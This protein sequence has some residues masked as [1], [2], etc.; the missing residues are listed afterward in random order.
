[1][2]S[3]IASIAMFEGA[4]CSCNSA[5]NCDRSSFLWAV[6]R[7]IRA[8]TRTPRSVDPSH[9]LQSIPFAFHDAGWGSGLSSSFGC[10]K[11]NIP[12]RGF[13][14]MKKLILFLLSAGLAWAQGPSCQFKG[15]F[16]SATTGTPYTNN[17]GNPNCN[18]FALTWNST[19]FTGL[20]IQL[21]GSD[22]N[23]TYTAFSGSS[24]V[25]VGSNPASTLSG[26][27]VVQASSSLA[28]IRV[29][30]PSVTGSGGINYQVYGYNG[31]TPAAR[32][33]GG[34]GGGGT[35]TQTWIAGTGGVTA[36]AVVCVSRGTSNPATA[37]ICPTAVVGSAE[38]NA[39]VLGIAQ[40]SAS[41]GASFQVIVQGPATCNFDSVNAPTAGDLAVYSFGNSPTGGLCQDSGNFTATFGVPIVGVVLTSGSVSTAQSVWVFGPGQYGS[42]TSVAS[43][44]TINNVAGS[45]N[46][47]L[48]LPVT[49]TDS[50]TKVVSF[51]S[52]S[53]PIDGNCANWLNGDLQDSGG[54]CGVT[55]QLWTAGAGGVTANTLVCVS[56]DST[57]T[58]IECPILTGASAPT[59]LGLA[60]SS[61]SVGVQ[62]T[63]NTVPGSVQNCVFDNTALIGDL[64]S[65]STST[66]GDCTD[67]GFTLL[68]ELSTFLPYVGIVQSSGTGAQSIMFVSPG[69]NGTLASV[70]GTLTYYFQ[71]TAA[72]VA[73][74]LYQQTTPYSPK[75]TLPYVSGTTV[76]TL[77]LQNWITPAGQP[78]VSFFPAGS[79]LFHIHASR[80][81]AFTG[82][83]T[84]QCQF[85]ETNSSGVDIAVIGTSGVT[86][87]LTLSEVEYIVQ[88]NNPNTYVLSSTASRIVARVQAN[89]NVTVSGNIDL[90]VGGEADSHITLPIN[91]VGILS[92]FGNSGP[93]VSSLTVPTGG[94]ISFSG[95]GTVNANQVNGTAVTGTSGNC[96]KFGAGN[97]LADNGSACGG[98]GGAVS[99]V[100]G[101]T[102]AVP[103]GL[104]LQEQHTASSSASLSFTSCISSTYDEY[105]FEILNLIPATNAVTG[106]L[107]MNSDSSSL[108]AWADWFVGTALNSDGQQFSNSDTSISLFV[109]LD[110]TS[111][112][113]YSGTLKLF[114]PSST[115]LDK[116]VTSHVTGLAGGFFYSTDGA[117][118][119]KSTSAV[120][121]VQFLFSSGNIASGTVRCYGIAKQ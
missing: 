64:V 1:M 57:N 78:G 81:N 82:S 32:G 49:T 8:T 89:V 103:G 72:D 83:I 115:S 117:G 105:Q 42:Y 31:V 87:N 94:S 41:A 79:Y 61:A 102:G 19:G 23:S 27:I 99:S 52:G 118:V 109:G 76:T 28:Y 95:S 38:I 24:T 106:I 40:G 92:I 119:Y 69:A 17:T 45:A 9:T 5:S 66:P 7:G 33:A 22:D 90:Y 46:Y 107:R 68:G 18:A 120:T 60:Q 62:F 10:M 21:E 2:R 97:T 111:T 74:Y 14:R 100:G 4:A 44:L 30:V 80:T 13:D 55:A 48:G 34:G 86:P 43:P 37:V 70:G 51:K 50:A 58:A 39:A 84:L 113:G 85:V 54:P 116:A 12:E 93:I 73:T 104:I 88:F 25:L 63:V 71:N 29:R 35:N 26:A 47:T 114:Q 98:G 56:G 108:Y 11:R 96:V 65:T 121:T 110:N 20:S 91:S 101:L 77:T 67:T 59:V 112:Y 53:T 3:G 75:T 36:N 16:A 6:T 15:T